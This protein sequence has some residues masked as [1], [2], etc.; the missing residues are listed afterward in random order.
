MRIVEDTRQQKGK[1]ERK[2]RWWEANGIEVV[3]RK[4]DFGDYVL[5]VESPSVSV[6]TKRDVA[7]VAANISGQ[8]ERFKRECL[9]ARDAGCLLVVLIENTD[10]FERVDD[11]ARWTNG[12]CLRC[13]RCDPHAL[14]KCENPRHKSTRKPVQ[15]ARLAK[16]MQTMCE[17]YGVEFVF[18]HPRDAAK[19][20]TEIVRRDAHGE[21]A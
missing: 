12:V 10:G 9:R 13:G 1:H 21:H 4:L 19:I 3:S 20:I 18:C 15:G 11:V 2:H 16:A 5:D 17:R 7:E 14:G 8:H 6:D